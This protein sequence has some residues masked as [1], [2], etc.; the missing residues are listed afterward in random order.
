MELVE[1]E[2]NAFRPDDIPFGER[3]DFN[4]NKF[5]GDR[6]GFRRYFYS[7]W[8]ERLAIWLVNIPSCVPLESR[9]I[10]CRRNPNIESI[11]IGITGLL[12]RLGQ[13]VA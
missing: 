10:Y 12:W 8:V 2:R 5:R 11:F 6:Y 3:F 4:Q 7:C 13:G 9:V 1:V